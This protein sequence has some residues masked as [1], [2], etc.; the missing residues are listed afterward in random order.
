MPLQTIDKPNLYFSAQLLIN[1]LLSKIADGHAVNH[2]IQYHLFELKQVFRDNV[3]SATTHLEAIAD[4]VKNY[5][6]LRN[7]QDI[8][9]G[10]PLVSTFLINGNNNTASIHFNPTALERVKSGDFQIKAID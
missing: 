8:D 4:L 10:V 7:A 9:N 3:A 6:V 5:V 1:H 2:Q